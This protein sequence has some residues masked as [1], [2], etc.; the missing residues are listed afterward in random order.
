[1]LI[2]GFVT[3][4]LAYRAHLTERDRLLEQGQH[5]LDQGLTAALSGRFEAMEPWLERAEVAGIDPAR[6]RMLRG[7]AALEQGDTETA[8]HHLELALERLPDSMGAKA[9]LARAY[10]VA[11]RWTE[12][13]PMMEEVFDG[14]PV[15]PE[16]HIYGAQ[17]AGYW[18][19]GAEKATD[20]LEA[21]TAARPIPAAHFMLG[22]QQFRA[23]YED[24]REDQIEP[25]LRNLTA[26]RVQMPDYVRAAM[27]EYLVHV[28]AADFHKRKGNDGVAT[29]HYR[30]AVNIA[31]EVVA[32]SPED[33]YSHLI[34]GSLAELEGRWREAVESYRRSVALGGGREG[35][36]I[37]IPLLHLERFGE[38]IKALDEIPEGTRAHTDWPWAH[39]FALAELDRRETAI[40]MFDRW[41]EGSDLLEFTE[42]TAA[43]EV[44]ALLGNIT[45]AQRKSSLLLERSLFQRTDTPFDR[46]LDSYICGHLS[47]ANP[48][49][50]TAKTRPQIVLASYLIGLEHLARGHPED[51][52]QSFES[53]MRVGGAFPAPYG[54][55]GGRAA[56]LLL[57][58]LR[59]DP[60]WPPWIPVASTSTTQPTGP[61]TRETRQ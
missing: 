33:R 27:Y 9:L 23:F 3:A 56:R 21:I 50:N 39:A 53:V 59:E 57:S 46:A 19:G 45:E 32:S 7:L 12:A 31:A 54:E 20:W 61:A 60:Q 5:A 25:T 28:H 29:D 38:A 30:R 44:Y 1:M 48:I 36:A 58:R 6:I 40:G 17:A 41:L 52:I 10:Q 42:R 55:H 2:T 37:P 34:E 18:P 26:A 35:Y 22:L 15:T 4:T 11:A 8:I 51:A 13:V 16:D 14:S 49:I 47:N 43:F 24:P